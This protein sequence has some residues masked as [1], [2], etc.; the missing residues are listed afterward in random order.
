PLL[1]RSVGE[2]HLL[3]SRMSVSTVRA[4]AGRALLLL[5]QP[6]GHRSTM[7]PVLL[8]LVV[9]ATAAL[10]LTLRALPGGGRLNGMP[11][12]GCCWPA[13]TMRPSG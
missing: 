7:P 4:A 10:D 11:R 12:V 13:T 5:R 9:A 2:T 8:V 6:P 3:R 1:L